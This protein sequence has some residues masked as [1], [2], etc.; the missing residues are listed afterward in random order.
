MAAPPSR[1]SLTQTAAGRRPARLLALAAWT[2]IVMLAATGLT[3]GGELWSRRATM[4]TTP[5]HALPVQSVVLAAWLLLGYPLR[6]GA[7]LGQGDALERYWAWLGL[8]LGEVALVLVVAAPFLVAGSI[9]SG[10]PLWRVAW[11]VAGLLGSVLVAICYRMIHE[12]LG[13]RVRALALLDALV[14]TL[15]PLVVG[16]L[17]LEFYGIDM[18]RWWL[19][20]PLALAHQMATTGLADWPAVVLIGGA[21]YGGVA[22]VAMAAV[23]PLIRRRRAILALHDEDPRVI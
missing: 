13:P 6:P 16:Y 2:A 20:S 5:A 18:G 7:L 23:R 21:G 8:R 10:V 14:F 4:L 17:L 11:I 15:G 19:V 22:A 1:S 9:F 12:T 3:V